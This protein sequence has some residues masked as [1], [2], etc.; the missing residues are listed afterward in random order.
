MTVTI[1]IRA[2]LCVSSWTRLLEKWT[3]GLNERHP[4]CVKS[5]CIDKTVVLSSISESN[6]LKP[7]LSQAQ[8]CRSWH[9]NEGCPYSLSK[10]QAHLSRAWGFDVGKIDESEGASDRCLP[11]NHSHERNNANGCKHGSQGSVE[12]CA[13]KVPDCAQRKSLWGMT[14]LQVR[15]PKLGRGKPSRMRCSPRESA[16]RS[17][18]KWIPWVIPSCLRWMTSQEAQD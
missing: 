2:T 12:T 13:N 9:I 14:L 5:V 7:R 15:Q 6:G 18:Q 16:P 10:N 8:E 4:K 3:W 11:K 1:G 17:E